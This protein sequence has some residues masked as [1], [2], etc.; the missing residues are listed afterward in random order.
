MIHYRQATDK[1]FD[2]TFQIKR[3]SL[4]PYVDKIWGWRDTEQSDFHRKEF[5][6]NTIRIVLDE[7]LIEVGYIDAE[8]KS[9]TIFIVNILIDEKYQ[10]KGAHRVVAGEQ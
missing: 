9:N 8:H 2:L 6:P 4:K 10:G 5:N 1:D 3:S 7:R